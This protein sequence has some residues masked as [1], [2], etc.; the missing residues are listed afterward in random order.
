MLSAAL[1]AQD[2]G[3]SLADILTAV[4]GREHGP[5]TMGGRV[6]DIA[7]YEKEPR[8]FYTATASGGLWKTINGGITNNVVFYDQPTVAL[9]A[10]A[11]SQKNPDLVYVGTGE[12]DSRNSTSWG[13]GVYKS[14]DGGKTWKNIGLKDSKHIGRI[15][16]DP[17]DDNT[18]YVA[19]LGHLWGSSKGRGLYKSTDG[20]QTWKLI[21]E[22]SDDLT[23]VVDVQLNPS[24]PEELMCA[25]YT[26]QR[27]AYAWASGGKGSALWKSTNGGKTWKQI[28]KGIPA[29]DKGRIGISYFRKNP[30]VVLT[31][32]ENAKEG[33]IYKSTDGGESFTKL[34]SLNPRPFY[35]SQIRQD[36]VDENRIYLPAVNFHYST[37]GGKTFKVLNT[38][39]HVDHHAMWINPN[40]N[41]HMIIGE[42]GGLGQ[43]R[44]QG[45]SWEHIKDLPI[46]Q[47]YAVAVDMRKPY[48]IYGGLQ[49]NGSWGGPSQNTING[50]VMWTDWFQTA[51][52][53][54][55]HVQVDPEDWRIVYSES[56]GGAISRLNIVTGEGRGIRPRPA[57]G[58]VLRFNW[59]TP[60][61]IS[62]F[63][64]Q[65]LY[66]GANK[67][68]KTTNRGDSWE[69]ISPD[70]TTN[71]TSKQTPGRGVSPE[72][73]G[74]ERHCTIITISESAK[75]QGV[76]YVGT[77]D[78]LVHVTKNGGKDWTNLTANIPG[79]PKNTW[80]SR[81]TASKFVAGRVYASFDGHRNNDYKPYAYVSEDYGQTWK[82][83][84]NGFVEND[85]VY[86]IKEATQNPDLLI[87]GTELGLYFSLNRGGS[88]TK[89]KSGTFATVRVDDVVVHPRD[90]DLVVATHGRSFWIL[91]FSGMEQLTEENRA[92]DVFLCK[93]APTYILGY[94]QDGW[95]G[96]DREFVSTN[97]Q[98]NARIEYWLKAATSE[99]VS[100]QVLS[101]DGTQVG[102][103]TGTGKAGLNSVNWRPG[104][105]RGGSGGTSDYTVVL[106]IGE[107]EYKTSLR[108]ED[109][110]RSS[111]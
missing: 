71:D 23:G 72:N 82:S 86:V 63:N 97:T 76:I 100:I 87:L 75:E 31:V 106:K 91:P 10:V 55:F 15:Q 70:L 107:K 53:D 5:T 21:L 61:I 41:N 74:A 56:Q 103:L 92:K 40:D 105:R 33:G 8:I 47:F 51:G 9:G 13:D 110:S 30:K 34:N 90:L 83:I 37:D 109:L 48:Y 102:T 28:T 94:T 80:C 1:F 42:D 14:T 32:I 57:Q 17:R 11:V 78:G 27:W 12:K 68:F 60:F 81:V 79:L 88:W 26:R 50:G 25:T 24:N 46:G 95:F 84:A 44:D 89:Y 73:T 49:D 19:V 29:D 18:L 93:P 39:V 96:G 45:Q 98:P 108:V 22:T 67:L 62:P 59:S 69:A 101:S 77:D 3:P 38:S 4:P 2:S 64:H 52:G 65:T 16:I 20:G 7:V 111:D 54:G 6:Q 104:G 35:F 43:T 85:C 66:L 36:P 99:R 58:E